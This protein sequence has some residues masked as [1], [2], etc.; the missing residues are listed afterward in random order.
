MC[1]VA[2][3]TAVMRS[4]LVTLS[5][6]RF[7][8]WTRRAPI[9]RMVSGQLSKA[10]TRPSQPQTR[11]SRADESSRRGAESSLAEALA[12]TVY[13]RPC[14]LSVRSCGSGDNHTTTWCL[15]SFPMLKSPR[16]GRPDAWTGSDVCSPGSPLRGRPSERGIGFSISVSAER[17]ATW[18]GRRPEHHMVPCQPH[19]AQK[20]P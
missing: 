5:A 10:Q 15:A 9:H 14:R 4:A 6:H 20:S 1:R 19:N 11:E 7:G 13:R 16:Y 2:G 17:P 12:A 8:S 18:I 3:D